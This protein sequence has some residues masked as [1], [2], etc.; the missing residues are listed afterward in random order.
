[1]IPAQALPYVRFANFATLISGDTAEKASWFEQFQGAVLAAGA[2]VP[3]FSRS[4][5]DLKT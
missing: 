4:M 5:S 1:M 2:R 3:R